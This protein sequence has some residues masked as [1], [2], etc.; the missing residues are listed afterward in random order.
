MSV[1]SREDFDKPVDPSVTTDSSGSRRAAFGR[2]REVYSLIPLSRS[3]VNIATSGLSDI[4]LMDAVYPSCQGR[5]LSG[6]APQLNRPKHTKPTHG[7]GPRQD[8]ILLLG[9]RE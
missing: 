1:E 7:E 4:E 6:L 3:Q 9:T 2:Q 5:L 8:P